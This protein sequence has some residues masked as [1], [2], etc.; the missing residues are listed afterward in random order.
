MKNYKDTEDKILGNLLRSPLENK[1]MHQVALD[2]KLSYVTVH[3]LVPYLLK[4]KLI[5]LERKGK[6]NLISIDFEQ[7]ELGKLSSAIL[8]EKSKI[9]E[10]Y[11]QLALLLREIEEVLA[12]K[13]YSL[14]LF[15]SYAKGKAKQD[16]D[17]DFLFIIPYR[18]DIGVYKEKISKALR[19]FLGV[20]EHLVVVSTQ[21]F[22]DMLNQKYTVGKAAF[23]E[24][25]VLFGTEQ[26]YAMVKKHV[27]KHGY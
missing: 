24:G 2:T 7:A 13:F 10:R 26:Y 12:G 18:K 23:Q 1:S 22:I 8:F 21:D 6:A 19:L 27:R 17:F 9:M 4:K 25:I 14:I 16:S 11:P 5:K 15:G 3:K 20:K